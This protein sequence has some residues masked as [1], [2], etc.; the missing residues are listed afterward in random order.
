MSWADPSMHD[1]DIG[2]VLF[3]FCFFSCTTE[4]E[5]LNIWVSVT[6]LNTGMH[7]FDKIKMKQYNAGNCV[8]FVR[9]FLT[10]NYE[11][12]EKREIYLNK[13]IP[14]NKIKCAL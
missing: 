10:M 6:Y 1:S 4:R 11:L 2:L 13:N 9:I 14:K 12:S 8:P 3:C 7:N 5:S